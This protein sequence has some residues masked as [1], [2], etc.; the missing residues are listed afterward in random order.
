MHLFEF[1]AGPS[2]ALTAIMARPAWG[3]VAAA[4]LRK[5]A[6]L[7]RT[8]RHSDRLFLFQILAAPDGAIPKSA[9]LAGQ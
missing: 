7:L 4:F 6:G 1:H 9:V 2:L 8:P 3:H 5:P